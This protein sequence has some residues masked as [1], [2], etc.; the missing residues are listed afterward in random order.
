L[1]RHRPFDASLRDSEAEA[2]TEAD[3]ETEAE[4]ETECRLDQVFWL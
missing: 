1:K 4:A 3:S 2:E